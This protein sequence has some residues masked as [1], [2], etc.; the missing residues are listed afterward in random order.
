MILCQPRRLLAF[1]LLSGPC[2]I[3]SEVLVHIDSEV[4]DLGRIGKVLACLALVQCCFLSLSKGRHPF[5]G[6]DLDHPL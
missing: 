5:L 4:D 3:A 2:S 1:E 6:Q